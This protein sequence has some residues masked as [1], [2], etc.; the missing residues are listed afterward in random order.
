[1]SISGSVGKV[2]SEHG[3]SPTLVV[4]GTFHRFQ[5]LPEVLLRRASSISQ[6]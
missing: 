1:M 3:F 4:P 6:I 2:E 5:E